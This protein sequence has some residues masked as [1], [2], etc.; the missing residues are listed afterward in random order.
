VGVAVWLL[1][2]VLLWRSSSL[3][4]HASVP[5]LSARR[6]FSQALLDRTAS[7]G[8]G[9][10]LI[11]V[12][13]SAAVLVVAAVYAWVTGRAQY[14]ESD[15]A[16]TG[17][18]LGLLGFVLLWVV[19]L[20][21]NA[22]DLWWQRRHALSHAGY[23]DRFLSDWFGLRSSLF[24]VAVLLLALVGLAHLIGDLWWLAAAPI[25][26]GVAAL[27]TFVMPWLTATHRV[28][29]P[30][31][32]EAARQLEERQG[33]SGTKVVVQRVRPDSTAPNAATVGFGPSRR[34]IVWDTLLDGRFTHRE[35]RVVLGHE[36]GHVAHRD[37]LKGLAWLALLAFPAAYALSL[38]ARRRGG[39]TEPSAVPAVV[40]G[41]VV[42]GV[43]AA[44][45]QNVVSRRIEADADWA[46]LDAARDPTAQRS[47]FVKFA[48][49][50][51]EEPD[52]GP[53]DYV[54]LET[55]PT[56]L[57]RIA[58]VEAWQARATADRASGRE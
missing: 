23:L 55:H 10:L 17:V 42:I 11:S 44:P 13:G 3:P 16:G 50:A 48:R 26:V 31:L 24:L 18:L 38:I 47:L 51:L 46:A 52:P 41:L 20:P 19:R 5:E 37:L 25:A 49:T 33:V 15:R 4:G 45:L 53:L 12:A 35:V 14:P 30:W 58:L 21:F 29:A 6:L 28:E 7:Y 34:V 39:L 2:A 22:A 40:L 1:L 36:L 56:L 32:R 43:V 54:L 9:Q 27:A 8:R 57:Q